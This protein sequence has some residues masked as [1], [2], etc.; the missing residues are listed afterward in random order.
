MIQVVFIAFVWRD[1]MCGAPCACSVFRTKTAVKSHDISCGA[2]SETPWVHYVFD[3][4][5]SFDHCAFRNNVYIVKHFETLTF[6]I[7]RVET[8]I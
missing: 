6:V 1:G 5:L 3:F 4:E 2:L 8:Q 7:P